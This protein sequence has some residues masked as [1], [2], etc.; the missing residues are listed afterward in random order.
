MD[1]VIHPKAEIETELQWKARSPALCYY[2]LETL[3]VRPL[4]YPGQLAWVMGL[5]SFFQRVRS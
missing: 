5:D 4:A 3:R 2:P 1:Y